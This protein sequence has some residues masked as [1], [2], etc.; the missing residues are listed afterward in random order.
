MV[1]H[2]I[3]GGQDRDFWEGRGGQIRSGAEVPVQ[4]KSSAE[5]DDW[6]TKVLGVRV[7]KKYSL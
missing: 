4:V 2:F 7:K 1:L 6:M 3:L 5:S